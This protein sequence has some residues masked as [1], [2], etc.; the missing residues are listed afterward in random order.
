MYPRWIEAM[1]DGDTGRHLVNY[2]KGR[3]S[4]TCA[5]LTRCSHRTAVELVTVPLGP[6]TVQ[7]DT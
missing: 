1:V 2:R 4:C 7:A 3:W 5:R 6:A